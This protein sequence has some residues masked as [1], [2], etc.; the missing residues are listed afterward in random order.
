MYIKILKKDLK[1]KKTMNLILVIIISLAAMF[2][3][4]SVNMLAVSVDGTEYFFEKAGLD[5]FI[6]V[7]TNNGNDR[8]NEQTITEKLDKCEYV[9]DF[10]EDE[11]AFIGNSNIKYKNKS[12]EFANSIMASS[13]KIHQQVFFDGKNNEINK[14]DRGEM[15]MPYSLMKENDIQPGDKI[16]IELNDYEKEFEVIDYFKDAFLGSSMMGSKRIIFNDEDFDEIKLNSDLVTG[17]IFSVNTNSMKKFQREFNEWGT[18][19]LFSD[20][21]TVIKTTYIFDL[22]IALVMFMVSICLVAISGVMLKFIIT[23]TINDDYKEIGIMKAIGIKDTGIRKL[24]ASKYFLFAFVGSIMGVI[25]SIPFGNT[26][27]TEVTV[28][29]I[30]RGNG[31][32]IITKIITVIFM[33]AIIVALAYKSTGRIKSLTPMDAIRSGN[34]GERFKR[35]GG[36]SLKK[37]K[38]SVSS[39]LAVNDIFSQ[40][41]TFLAV[42]IIGII[43]MWLIAMFVNTINTLSSPNILQWF[44]ILKSDV[45]ITDSDMIFVS[46]KNETEIDEKLEDIKKDIE[47]DGI[48]V[49]RVHCEMMY[50]FGLKKGDLNTSSLGFKGYGSTANEYTYGE[51]T[52]PKYQNE[53]AI[54]YVISEKIDAHIGD[55]VIINMFNEDRKY[56]VT[57]LFQSMNNFGEG[58]RF[59][60]EVEMDLTANSG[61]FGIQVDFDDN[62]NE[63]EKDEQF[64]KLE[65]K[66][67]KVQEIMEFESDMLGGI[68][69]RLILYKAMILLIV[70]IIVTLVIVLIQKM[71][72]IRERGVMA[73]MK[74]IGFTSNSIILWQIKRITIVLV[75]GVI[76]GLSTSLPF[77]KITIG[78]VF[79]I[80][81]ATNID[82]V[83][84][85]FELYILYPMIV[86]VA[87]IAVCALTMLSIRKITVQDMH[88]IE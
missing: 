17:S 4:S 50:R 45:I 70:I 84:N 59:G 19:S 9:E 65:D 55:E 86:V 81:G 11:L 12:I 7:T 79:K 20:T 26:L 41:R 16:K 34:N 13:Y 49:K 2:V 68:I 39:F 74:S 31:I 21:K 15:Y 30:T 48:K 71:F 33:I 1:R 76:V 32:N 42:F 46:E 52:P 54:S 72:L 40:M 37:S 3:A 18:K 73:M 28:N 5:D 38:L 87:S 69:E 66:Y 64:K 83:V 24:Y 88:N 57:A 51:G 61:C 82:F 56:V 22:I 36:F 63:K 10:S 44:S 60:D 62:L 6:I 27:L 43:G 78:Q 35:K 77:S 14:L 85:K 67:E 23:F 29:I 8:S 58:I 75:A 47:K 80:M 53:I 25:V